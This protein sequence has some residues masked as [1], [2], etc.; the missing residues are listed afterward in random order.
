MDA[1]NVHLLTYANA[2]DL[3]ADASVRQVTGVRVK[4]I[5]GKSHLVRARYF[6]LACGSIQNARLLLCSNQQAP[7]G[8]GNDHDLV[9][10]FFMEHL[11]M[12]GAQLILERP[13]SLSLYRSRF[14]LPRP[15]SGELALTEEMQRRHRVLNGTV[16]LRPGT[17][18]EEMRSFFMRV[19]DGNL[20]ERLRDDGREDRRRQNVASWSPPAT[21]EARR[22]F[23]MSSRAEQ[24]PNPDSRVMLSD[25]KDALGMRRADL[26]WK[27]T[28][29]DKRSMRVLYEVLAN[30]F[31]R[32]GLGRVQILD[33]LLEDDPTWPSFLSGG[34]HHMGTTRMHHDAREG[35]VDSNCRVHG[36]ANLFMAGASVFPHLWC[37]QPD[38][39][40]DCI[41]ASA[42]RPPE[43]AG[44]LTQVCHF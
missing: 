20:G 1:D 37:T 13:L 10:R 5:D 42:F 24:A 11:E 16:S 36:M 38:A 41:V 9:G 43:R 15:A 19:R 31:G 25:K 39:H 32:T 21:V 29:L 35:V 28:E 27:L 17:F 3:E 30:E 8:L 2:V 23:Q 26:H 22:D 18:P 14:A 33:W 44:G 40:P 7:A 34:F 4:T 12:G 6:A